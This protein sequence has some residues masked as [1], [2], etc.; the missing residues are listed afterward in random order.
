MDGTG[1]AAI[2]IELTTLAAKNTAAIVSDKIRQAKSNRDLKKQNAELRD[3][4]NDLLSDKA[5]LVRIAQTYQQELVSQEITDKDISYITKHLI[6]I[7]RRFVPAEQ[8]KTIEQLQ[9][10]FSKETLTI[11]QLVGFNYKK[12]IGEPLTEL[13]C[14]SIRSKTLT[15]A[16]NAENQQK[17]LMATIELAKDKEAYGRFIKLT[18]TGGNNEK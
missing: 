5:D 17:V 9:T 2:G 10:A 14:N 8:S 7:L 1:L 15:P 16:K 3:I 4:I 18:N 6:P 12:A 11:L 13:V